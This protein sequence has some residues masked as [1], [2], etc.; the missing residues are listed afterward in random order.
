M[1]NRDPKWSQ[2]LRVDPIIHGWRQLRRWPTTAQFGLLA[3]AILG[4]AVFLA[5]TW[6]GSTSR[7]GEWQP[8]MDEAGLGVAIQLD[9]DKETGEVQLRLDRNALSQAVPEARKR[10]WVVSHL[11]RFNRNLRGHRFDPK[12]IPGDSIFQV[13]MVG[14]GAERQ[15]RLRLRDLSPFNTHPVRKY[16]ERALGPVY[17]RPGQQPT[18][19]LSDGFLGLT[20]EPGDGPTKTVRLN[21][22]GLFH[23][24]RFQLVDEKGLGVATIWPSEDSSQVFIQGEAGRGV[25]IDNNAPLEDDERG[26]GA[27]EM[28]ELAGRF[29]EVRIEAAPVLAISAD[30]G[31]RQK[32]IYP[33]GNNLHFVGPVSLNGRHQSLGLE[34]MFQEYLAGLPE[35]GIPQGELWL[36]IDPRLQGAWVA[37]MSQLAQRSER[38]SGRRASGLLMDAKTGAILAMAAEQK[39]YD[40]GDT[41]QILSLLDSG[42]ERFAN[43]GCFRRHVIGSVTKP[44]FAFLALALDPDWEHAWV[45]VVGENSPTLYGHKLYGRSGKAMAFKRNHIDFGTYL[46]QSDNA[47]QHSLGLLMLAGLRDLDEVP[48]PWRAKDKNGALI[49]RPTYNADTPLE[50]HHLGVGGRDRLTVA[51]DSPFAAAARAIFDLETAPPGGVHDDRDLGIFEG[52]LPMAE[53]MLLRHNPR[54]QQPREVLKRRSVVCAPEF[55][56]LA[57]ESVT[58]TKDASNLL[59]G[60]NF[61]LWTDVKL[62]E[63]FSRMM[64]GRKVRARI[65]QQYRDTLGEGEV[66]NLVTEAEPF[67]V[68]EDIANPNAFGSMRK[69]LSQVPVRGTGRLI[70]PAISEIRNQP[71]Q[72]NF[73]LFAKTGTID[74][75]EGSDS[76]LFLATFGLWDNAADDFQGSA[77]TFVIYLRNAKQEND[78][79]EFIKAELPKWWR[80]LQPAQPK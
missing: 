62:C 69:Y 34:Y 47:Y 49:L 28:V 31:Q 19:F 21:Q 32:R 33:M 40:P 18:P 15:P 73:R 57:L 8:L 71:G 63:A 7:A 25:F 20:L 74:D 70:A 10:R 52:F 5:A 67:R 29:F 51:R 38:R 4:A 58:N 9:F 60:G 50:L 27:G 11:R 26:L 79:L 42:E 3:T 16:S 61:N 72:A 14:N 53:T 75:G 56:R 78:I 22:P 30:R 77:F 36:T 68:P 65:V 64:T 2:W 24:N 23:A 55:P 13:D 39:P 6:P 17:M 80:L 45:D 59:F 41:S 54:L 37:G 43:H 44:F 48:K 76:R 1:V 35:A 12:R 46:I 66:V